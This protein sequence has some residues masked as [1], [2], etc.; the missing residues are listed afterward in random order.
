MSQLTTDPTPDLQPRWSP[1]GKEVAFY[2]YRSGNRDIWVMPSGGGPARQ[3]TSH[4]AEDVTPAWSPSGQEIAF[5]SRRSG[6]RDIWVVSAK[7]GEARQLTV[8]PAAES[9][10]VWSLD[11]EWV[12]FHSWREDKRRYWR[13]PAGGGEPERRSKGP[14]QMARWSPDGRFLYFPGVEDR[15]GQLWALS[16]EDGREYPVADLSGR[17]GTLGFSLATDG[18]YLYFNW[19]HD[20]GDIWVMDVVR[21]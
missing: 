1:D 14:A 5:V 21:E 8:D 6:N 18:Q 15:D 20:V 4:P 2:S 16:V 12:F 13:M 17:R 11:G 19:A 3:L 10:P 9:W 7:G